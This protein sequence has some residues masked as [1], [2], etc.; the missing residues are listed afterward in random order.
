MSS[1]LF[2]NLEGKKK[3]GNNDKQISFG[4]GN[5]FSTC[6]SNPAGILRLGGSAVGVGKVQGLKMRYETDP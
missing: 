1:C 6:G 3:K 2:L 4:H 5:G